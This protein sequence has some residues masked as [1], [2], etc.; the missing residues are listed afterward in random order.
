MSFNDEDFIRLLEYY[1][2]QN[3]FHIKSKIP[4]DTV[5]NISKSGSDLP[6][7]ENSNFYMFDFDNLSY[8]ANLRDNGKP[9][10][11]LPASC[12]GLYFDKENKTVYFFEFKNLPLKSIDYKHELKSIINELKSG[13]GISNNIIEKLNEIYSRF[14]DEIIC[15]LKIKTNDSLFFCLP[16]IYESYCEKNGL[17]FNQC[18]NDFMLWILNSNKKFIF[19][20]ADNT[21]ISPSNTHFSFDIRLRDKLKHFE[22]I[23]RIKTI[24]VNKT[25]F[26]NHLPF[27]DFDKS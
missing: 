21:E 13:Y 2:N 8:N 25:H 20:F 1:K 23:A 16:I 24:I 6:F 10:R 22:N 5:G 19:V 9:K 3:N 11:N 26:E 12:D 15:K 4:Y 17:N 27:K 18:Q 7:I 14:E